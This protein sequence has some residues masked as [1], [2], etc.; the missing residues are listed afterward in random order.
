MPIA[1]KGK[2]ADEQGF[3]A[4]GNRVVAI[5]QRYFR[6]SEVDTL[7]GDPSKAA[8]KLGWRPKVKFKELVAEMAREDLREAERVSLVR[9]HGYKAP[10][11]HE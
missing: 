2:G 4:K 7:L 10:D 11:Q 1:W 3:D 6:P 5:D 9:K 8:K